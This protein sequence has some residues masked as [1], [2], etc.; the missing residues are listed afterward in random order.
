MSKY[1]SQSTNDLWSPSSSLISLGC[2]ART[3]GLSS[4]NRRVQ[5]FSV[6]AGRLLLP[7][8]KGRA[9]GPPLTYRPTGPAQMDA[10]PLGAQFYYR[11]LSDL[12]QVRIPD[13]VL[14]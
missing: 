12:S 14:L 10:S 9:I 2:G 5:P 8:S 1:G 6:T 7:Y 11:Q 4:S 3:S 13:K